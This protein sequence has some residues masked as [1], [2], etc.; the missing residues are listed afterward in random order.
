MVENEAHGYATPADE[1]WPTARSRHRPSQVS[2]ARPYEWLMVA[3]LVTAVSVVVGLAVSGLG[4]TTGGLLGM[5]I[6][7]IAL[8]A[9]FCISAHRQAGEPRGEPR[10]AAPDWRAE[11][12]ASRRR[13]DALRAQYAAY[14]CDPLAVLRL[15][16]L[17]DVNVA[18]TARFVDA[19]AQAQGLHSERE[20]P[21]PPEDYATSYSRAVERAWQS[22]RAAKDAAERIRMSGLSPTERATVQR[23]IKLLTTAQDSDNGAERHIAYAKARAELAKLEHAGT[24]HL[25]RLALAA[26]D[27]SAR[28][29]LPTASPTPPTSSESS[30]LPDTEPT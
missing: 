8:I 4:T 2:T 28:P 21:E 25:P 5:V 14:E 18:S 22:W 15:P 20:D 9:H 6:F 26:L 24:L 16:A 10:L 1:P 29:R 23:I 7:V 27:A 11:W 12:R 19:F 17:A 30:A 13:F 3:W